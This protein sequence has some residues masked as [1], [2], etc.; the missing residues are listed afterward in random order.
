[1]MLE[2][3]LTEFR[4]KSSVPSIRLN[5]EIKNFKTKLPN[6]GTDG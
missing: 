6:L 5:N 2:V 4:I 3:N 1:M